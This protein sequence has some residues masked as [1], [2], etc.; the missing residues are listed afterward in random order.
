MAWYGCNHGRSC[1][2]QRP[3]PRSGGRGS[4]RELGLLFAFLPV[5]HFHRPADRP[6]RH[7]G[8]PLSRSAHW[9]QRHIVLSAL[10]TAVVLG[11]GL[12]V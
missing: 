11:L 2:G 4:Q 5:A 8:P 3:L 12:L 7:D 10:S 1:N 6:R 9:D